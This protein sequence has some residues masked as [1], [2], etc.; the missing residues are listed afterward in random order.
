MLSDLIDRHPH[1]LSA[2][3]FLLC[4]DEFTHEKLKQQVTGETY[5]HMMSG[6]SPETQLLTG[7]G[8]RIPE[9]RYPDD[10][11]WSDDLGNLP[12]I[13][14]ATLP[15]ASVQPDD[16]FDLLAVEVPR[17]PTQSV[18]EHHLAFLDLLATTTG[19]RRWVER[20][21]MSTPMLPGLIRA[22]PT[23]KF[24]YLTRNIEA[25][26]RSMSRHPMFQLMSLQFE[27]RSGRHPDI[28]FDEFLDK[29]PTYY[30]ETGDLFQ[31]G[32]SAEMLEERGKQQDRFILLCSFLNKMAE[33]AIADIPARNLLKVTYEQLV[34]N[35]VGQLR[36]VGRFLD[37]E[38]W[39]A[40]AEQVAPQIETRH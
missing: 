16:L 37:F 14:Q 23:A 27:V 11:R 24:V 21:G 25:N 5:W 20:S 19:H 6:P 26:A 7:L 32:L 22:Y 33:K 13:L 18:A 2:Q 3:E 34:A 36:R 15:A 40:W 12:R 31:E 17:F 9:F 39:P 35:P 38:D 8:I 28:S 4:F 10:G 29:R 1:T 30:M